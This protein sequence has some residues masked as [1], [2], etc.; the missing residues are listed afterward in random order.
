MAFPQ[1]FSYPEQIEKSITTQRQNEAFLLIDSL[2]RYT[3]TPDGNYYITPIQDT[4]YNNYNINHQKING[5]GQMT[6]CAITEYLW[7]WVTPNVNERNQYFFLASGIPGTFIYI[8]V[9]EGFYN[10]TEL[11]TTMTS[12]LN[13]TQYTN[14]PTNTPSTYGGNT[15]SV[16][17]DPKTSKFTITNSNPAISFWITRPDNFNAPYD[18]TTLIGYGGA[19]YFRPATLW[20]ASV[21]Y[22]V[23]AIVNWEN[24]NYRCIAVPPIGTDPA[25]NTYWALESNSSYNG[26]LLKWDDNLILSYPNA[27]PWSPTEQYVPDIIVIYN[28]RNYNCI[29]IPPIGTLP[30]N[31]TYWSL[32]PQLNVNYWSPLVNSYTGAIPT[33]AYT[34]YIDV[35]SNALTKFQTLKDTLT[36]FNYTN[37]ICRIYLNDGMNQPNTFFGSRPS[38]INRQITDPKFMKWNVDQMISGIDI[39]YRDDSGDLLYI[40]NITA[41]ATGKV[42]SNDANNSR[43]LFTMKL[44]EFD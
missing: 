9:P 22:A 38:T 5:L 3:L 20:S 14:Y 1:R 15:W 17:V 36:Q 13:N 19:R 23:G 7:D 10:P 43:Q 39:S 6:K 4:T 37:I 40:P 16:T 8:I 12:L 28:N 2:D 42:S 25:N 29:A 24:A 44:T 26:K 11:A 41:D 33:M 32:L 18:I 34:Q 27:F 31:L 21:V 30:T 35:C